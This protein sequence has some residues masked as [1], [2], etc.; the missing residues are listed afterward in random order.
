MRPVGVACV[1]LG[2]TCELVL[3]F[4]LD[5]E[6]DVAWE[7]E[8]VLEID[9]VGTGVLVTVVLKTGIDGLVVEGYGLTHPTLIPSLSVPGCRP[10][11]TPS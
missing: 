6:A 7:L 5:K 10:P 4:V 9:E 3:V 1:E 11:T 2:D 8:P